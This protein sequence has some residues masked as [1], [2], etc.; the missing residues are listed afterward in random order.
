FGS[1]PDSD[2]VAA[3]VGLGETIG[4][5]ATSTGLVSGRVHAFRKVGEFPF[6]I[7][8]SL[9]QADFLGDWLS[10]LQLYLIGAVLLVL[11]AVA[12]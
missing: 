12:L 6:T 2:P 8:V 11:L 9:N 7:V 5:Q 3:R 4:S 10:K 1:Q